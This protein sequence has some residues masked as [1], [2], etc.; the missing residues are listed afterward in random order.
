MRKIAMMMS[1]SVDGYIAG[2]NGEIDW[3]MVDDELHQYVN[4]V[5]GAMGAF[6]E[7][8]VVYELMEEFWPTA[9]QD[10]STP[11]T[12]AEF[13]RIWR[14]MPKLVF[15]RTLESAGPNAI[16]VRDVVAEE[17]EALKAEDGGDLSVGG[18]ELGA[19]F[20]EKGL[21][22][23]VWVYVH[24]VVIGAGKP[25][26]APGSHVD[27]RLVETRAFGNGVVLLRY[28]VGRG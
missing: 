9:D 11:A 2:P 28:A 24:P 20:L 25:L 15:S 14:R 5:L 1:V 16:V 4:G 22:D 13:A 10:P 27:L 3:H 17:I 6:V 26:F 8:R 12:M 18:A 23:E 21:M 7:G 19:A